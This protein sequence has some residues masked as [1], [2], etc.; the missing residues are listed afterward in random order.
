MFMY[1]SKIDFVLILFGIRFCTF[2]IRFPSHK[3]FRRSWA[4]LF[5][6]VV[7]FRPNILNVSLYHKLN[8]DG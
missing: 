5:P 4:S 3:I 6:V 8:G 1:T 7:M 2:C